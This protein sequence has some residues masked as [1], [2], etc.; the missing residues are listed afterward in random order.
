M[1]QYYVEEVESLKK[2]V[3]RNQAKKETL[4]VMIE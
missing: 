3:D 2:A 4:L 1:I